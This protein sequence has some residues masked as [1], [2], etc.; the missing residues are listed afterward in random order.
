MTSHKS[1][2]STVRVTNKKD[3]KKI[4]DYIYSGDKFGFQRKYDKYYEI[5]S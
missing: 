4:L 3:C 2:R 5:I 1:G